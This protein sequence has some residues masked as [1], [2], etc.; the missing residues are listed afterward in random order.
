MKRLMRTGIFLVAAVLIAGAGTPALASRSPW[1]HF[2]QTGGL[3]DNGVQAIGRDS[4]GILWIGTQGGVS[5]F[6]GEGWVNLLLSTDSP[7]T[8]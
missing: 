2:D 7:T 8:T 4:G 3:I 5:R 1:S 6:D